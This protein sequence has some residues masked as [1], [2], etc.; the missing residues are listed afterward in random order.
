MHDEVEGSG[1][2]RPPAANASAPGRA[3]RP[4]HRRCRD[5]RWTC[6]RAPGSSSHH[7]GHGGDDRER[8]HVRPHALG[9][10]R[11]PSSLFRLL[12]RGTEPFELDHVRGGGGPPAARPSG[13]GIAAAAPGV[14]VMTS[15][16]AGTSTSRCASCARRSRWCGLRRSCAVY[17]SRL[18]HRRSSATSAAS[19]SGGLGVEAELH[20]HGRRSGSGGCCTQP[21]E[22]ILGG[23]RLARCRIGLVRDRVGQ[24]MDPVRAVR[25]PQVPHV[26]VVGGHRCDPQRRQRAWNRP[27]SQAPPS[28]AALL[29]WEPEQRS[30][31]IRPISCRSKG[32][33]PGGTRTSGGRQRLR[34]ETGSAS[35]ACLLSARVCSRSAL[36]PGPPGSNV[37]CGMQLFVRIAHKRP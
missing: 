11:R 9:R 2:L 8:G 5:G 18:P 21:G 15:S 17:T 16:A 32:L 28:R 22:S 20:V 13:G 34:A 3:G 19:T 24:P 10:A 30:K 27:Q 6:S 25:E 37:A 4:R 35:W 7:V 31:R 33:W 14:S 26:H 36:T 23:Y 12:A 29:L 1:C